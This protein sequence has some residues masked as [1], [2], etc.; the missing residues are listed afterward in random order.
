MKWR[1]VNLAIVSLNNGLSR[2]YFS[3]VDGTFGHLC[4]RLTSSIYLY[5]L[6]YLFNYYHFLQ[7]G[8][9][10][11]LALQMKVNS[12][13]HFIYIIIYEKKWPK[14]AHGHTVIIPENHTKQ[15]PQCYF[16]IESFFSFLA[17]SEIRN[18]LCLNTYSCDFPTTFD[19]TYCTQYL[20]T[21]LCLTCLQKLEQSFSLTISCH[22]KNIFYK[23]IA[24]TTFKRT[25]Q[26][27]S[28]HHRYS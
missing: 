19:C 3:K 7:S 24:P 9:G 15:I 13:F 1:D 23:F 26:M 8:I 6:K 21:A 25:R 27:K 22:Q 5:L 18:L 14:Q 16:I 17:V 28:K 10:T 20:P 12:S 11:Y 2:S 4:C